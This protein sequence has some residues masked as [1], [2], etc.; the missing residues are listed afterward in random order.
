LGRRAENDTVL[1]WLGSFGA[2]ISALVLTGVSEGR[3]GL[4]GLLSRLFIW[5]VGL[6]WYLISLLLVPVVGLTIAILYVLLKGLGSELPE[7][8]YWHSTLWQQILIWVAGIW[9][10]VAIAPGEELGWR[11]YAL[12]RLQATVHPLAASILLGLLWGMW[13]FDG[14]LSHAANEYSLVDVLG[15]TAG[16]ISASVIYTWLF[17][18]TRGSVLIASIFH[19]AYDITVIWVAAILPIPPND[20]WIGLIGLAAIALAIILLAGPQL[21]YPILRRTEETNQGS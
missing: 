21:S 10:G 18:N 14:L 12:P 13:H 16:T 11:G 8:E 2:A 19:A 4:R 5:R 6:K 20:M 9:L 1:T 3:D 17:N 15:F 7:A